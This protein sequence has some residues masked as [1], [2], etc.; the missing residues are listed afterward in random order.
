MEK[1]KVLEKEMKIKAFSKEG[2]NQ[3]TKL[4]PKMKEKI[5]LANWI[6]STV[7]RLNTQIDAYEAEVET[8]NLNQKKGKKLESSKQERSDLL[9]STVEKHKNHIDKLEAILRLMENDQVATE[10]V[11]L[12]IIRYDILIYDF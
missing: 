7:D 3:A 2:L 6:N 8:I 4:D 9:V 5:D 10:Q 12:I 11:K 1:F